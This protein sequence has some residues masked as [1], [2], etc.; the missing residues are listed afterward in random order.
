MRLQPNP[1]GNLAI[2]A[3]RLRR[4]LHSLGQILHHEPHL[5]VLPRQVHAH[6]PVAPA[7]V[8]KRP[9]PGVEIGEVVP[10]DYVLDL[11]PLSARQARHGPAHALRARGVLAEGDEHGLLVDCAGGEVEPRLRQV[12]GLR[13][14][15]QGLQHVRRG[16]E[17]V[18][19][20]EAD[21][22]LQVLV[23]GQAPR[24]GRVR[25]LAR[26]GLAEDVAGDGVPHQPREVDLVELGPGGQFGEGD[27]LV[28]REQ[29]GDA[30]GVDG[31]QR[32]HVEVAPCL[33]ADRLARADGQVAQFLGGV[34]D[35]LPAP[36]GG[37][38]QFG[39]VVRIGVDVKGGER[40][41]CFLEVGFEGGCFCGD[42]LGQVGHAGGRFG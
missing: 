36:A 10:V 16:R 13:V 39:G 24:G 7:H 27:G 18:L 41:V 8:D 2:L 23:F 42:L 21:P 34:D 1:L 25:Y 30:E 9:L 12:H 29:L 40:E 11:V 3:N 38:G 19:R 33:P 17:D 4:A 14:G 6:K 20:V 37:L 15:A 28:D 26:R 5:L 31:L 22:G 35:L 32:K